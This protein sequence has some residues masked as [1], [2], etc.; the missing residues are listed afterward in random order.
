MYSFEQ[1][2]LYAEIGQQADLVT[3]GNEIDDA[4]A[5]L[6]DVDCSLHSN[7]VA[8][9][10]NTQPVEAGVSLS[11]FPSLEWTPYSNIN[12][13]L[14]HLFPPSGDQ[15]D[16]INNMLSDEVKYD[17]DVVYDPATAAPAPPVPRVVNLVDDEAMNLHYRFAPRY[18]WM[19]VE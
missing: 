15:N 9:E 6:E 13:E 19:T 4:N 2:D 7:L 10:T 17:D 1:V 3:F 14:E 12:V 16:R 11:G 8:R 18:N 5:H